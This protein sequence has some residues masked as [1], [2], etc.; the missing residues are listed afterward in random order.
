MHTKLDNLIYYGIMGQV[1]KVIAVF[2]LL[3]VA[4]FVLWLMLTKTQAM[5]DFFTG[6]KPLIQMFSKDKPQTTLTPTTQPV[7]TDQSEFVSQAQ[8]TFG[9]SAGAKNNTQK[10]QT[11]G[12]ESV[13]GTAQTPTP[14]PKAT[15]YPKTG[16]GTVILPLS[17]LGF[18]A[19]K[20][21]LKKTATK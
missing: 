5:R 15:N 10:T 16:A 13:L 6:R 11:K 14:V 8:Q 21:L 3:A 19:G 9:E 20:Y 2:L 17:L 7:P 4:I 1:N 12:G 18:A